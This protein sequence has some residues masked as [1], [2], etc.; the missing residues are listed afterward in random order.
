MNETWYLYI[1]MKI[2]SQLSVVVA[3]LSLPTIS[4]TTTKRQTNSFK[5]FKTQPCHF[6]VHPSTNSLNHYR[7]LI[8]HHFHDATPLLHHQQ[9]GSAMGRVSLV[10]LK[11]K[12]A[13]LV[14]IDEQHR[15]SDTTSRL[16]RP[17]STHSPS[18]LLA[19]LSEI[20]LIEERALP[21]ASNS[22]IPLTSDNP[23]APNPKPSWLL[24]QCNIY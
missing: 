23:L 2:S 4:I 15:W 12:D 3:F 1:Y 14:V 11:R 21:L 22:T 10:K 13:V 24:E 17:V 9:H 7:I 20:F 5:T 16:T 6:N 19:L 8:P 18:K